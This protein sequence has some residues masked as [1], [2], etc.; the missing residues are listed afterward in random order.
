MD[1]QILETVAKT[2]RSL[3]ADGVEA[4]NSGHP[5]LPLGMAEFGAWLFA[6]RLHHNPANS[7]WANRDRFVLSAGH[8]SMFIYSLLH[9]SGYRL[10]LEELKNFRQLNSLTPGHPEYGHTH[11]IETTTGP[12]GQGFANAVG[13]AMAAAHT[14][15]KFNTSKHKIVDHFVYTLMGDGCMMEGISTEAASLAG[16]LK[17]GRLI[18]FYDSNKI[19]I[20]GSTDLAFSENVGGKFKAMGWQVLEANAYDISAM[21]RALNSAGED[22]GRPS[23]IILH[24]VIGKGAPNKEGTAGVHGAPLGSE[25]LSAFRKNIG[26]PDDAGNEGGFYKLPGVEEFFSKKRRIWAEQEKEW[27]GLFDV[28]ASEN[29]ALHAEWQKWQEPIRAENLPALDLSEGGSS[30]TG[31]AT[32]ASSG[33]ALQTLSATFANLIGGSADLAPSN[34]TLIKAETDFAAGN[35]GGREYPLRREGARNGSCCQ[36]HGALRRPA[37]LRSDLSGVQRL[38]APLYST[39]SPYGTSGDLCIHPRLYLRRGRW[40]DSSANRTPRRTPDHSESALTAP[41]RCR[42]E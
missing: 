13:M 16:H 30:K 27:Q 34:N 19:S 1:I 35:Y 36:W 17:L 3:S 12:L 24:S 31:M 28:W 14:A 21:D 9:L 33:L 37:S 40:P 20:E 41:G 29:P 38:Y 25:E 23:L 39:R 11:G 4:A 5:G 26:L 15:A 10:P 32:R 7:K 42:G 8:G 22:E 18:A 2:I 6:E